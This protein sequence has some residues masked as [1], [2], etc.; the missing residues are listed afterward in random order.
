MQNLLFGYLLDPP[1]EQQQK[2]RVR[3]LLEGEVPELGAI[4][5]PTLIESYI[6]ESRNPQEM[7]RVLTG[8]GIKNYFISAKRLNPV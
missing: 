4:Y 5:D 6:E 1:K 3:Q 8:Q 2:R 7:T